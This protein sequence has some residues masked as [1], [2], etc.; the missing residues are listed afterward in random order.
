MVTDRVALPE[1]NEAI[2]NM[3]QGLP[4]HILVRP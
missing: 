4:I 1:I 3:R 2:A